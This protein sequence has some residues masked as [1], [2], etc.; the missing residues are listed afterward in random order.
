M[1]EVV[2]RASQTA[3]SE[4]AHDPFPG[5]RPFRED[6]R[7]LF[8][9]RSRE[10]NQLRS[11]VLASSLVVLYSPSGA[12][13]S[14]LIHAGLV[15]TLRKRGAT[16][17]PV[18]RIRPTGN[19]ELHSRITNPYLEALAAN[20][21]AIADVQQ[22]LG[23]A[24]SHAEEMTDIADLAGFVGLLAKVYDATPERP[25]VLI[26]DQF[27]ELFT[28]LPEYWGKRGDVFAQIEGAIRA[29]PGLSV[30]LSM[31]EDY[32]A[33]TD[34]YAELVSNH[35]RQR[36]RIETL[37]E[38]QALE[39]IQGP[40]GGTGRRFAPDAAETLVQE[41]MQIRI[42]RGR[43]DRRPDTVAGEYVEPVQLQVVCRRFWDDLPDDVEEITKDHVA[44]YADVDGALMRFYD[45]AIR[46]AASTDLRARE[47]KIRAWI[48][49]DLITAGRTRGTSHRDAAIKKGVTPG[50][51]NELVN[52]HLLKTEWRNGSDWYEIAHD[53]LIDPIRTSNRRYQDKVTSRRLRAL[54][55]ATVILLLVAVAAV[56]AVTTTTT[57]KSAGTMVVVTRTTVQ[58]SPADPFPL[59]AVPRNGGLY[60]KGG[61]FPA[62]YSCPNTAAGPAAACSGTVSHGAPI[63]TSDIGPHS[64]MVTATYGSSATTSSTSSY[65]VVGFASKTYHG[66]VFNI[67]YPAGWRSEDAESPQ[68]GGYTD[69][70]IVS[71]TSAD[72]RLRVDVTRSPAKN[73]RPAVDAEVH[74][75]AEESGYRLLSL[76]S[77]RFEGNAAI[78]WRFVVAESGVTLQKDDLFF[79]TVSDR[80]TSERVAVLTQAPVRSFHRL[81]GEFLLLRDTIV[82]PSVYYGPNCGQPHVVAD[83]QLTTGENCPAGF[84]LQ[85]EPDGTDVCENKKSQPTG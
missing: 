83:C 62:S 44:D 16:V 3:G 79:N 21:V 14:S 81:A 72:T 76:K 1:V 48:G 11:V 59:I 75:V 60:R 36:F 64:F 38:A 56:L 65:K 29:D 54:G 23:R 78:D 12:G 47:R 41:L 19:A 27:E 51:L 69:T 80:G 84:G 10:T 63:D 17:Y 35:L 25:R 49:E 39:A 28:F 77:A 26:I 33:Q 40:I 55:T 73:L 22:P 2:D 9:G 74:T 53:R 42:D 18:L 43:T 5:P 8:Y 67:A 52:W 30:L 45:D 32:I 71:P 13:K 31:R 58:V 50:V 6:E 68:P 34:P 7:D 82:V 24:R 4:K 66:K 70:T 85:T 57:N 20:W 46:G 37:R 15:P 61:V